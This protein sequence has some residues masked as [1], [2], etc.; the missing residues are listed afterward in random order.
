M[1]FLIVILL[2][3]LAALVLALLAARVLGRQRT[4][5]YG[6]LEALFD[7]TPDRYAH[8][9]RIL[10]HEDFDFLA[11]SRR[12]RELLRRLRQQ[13]V[14]LMQRY[15]A[16]M[17]EE[18]ESLMAVGSL[19]AAAPTA[20]A[21]NFARR[22]F[23]QRLRFL[24]AF[25]RLQACTLVNHV[26]AWPPDVTLLDTEIRTLRRQADRVLHALTPEDLGALR[27]FLRSS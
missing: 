5:T 8:L 9:G 27:N 3:A 24:I 20:Q 6:D 12:G 4:A 10:G 22:L 15:L 14:G 16:Q 23:R 18:F 13:R 7:S 19:F 21:E 25:Y 17:G 11:A 2:A 1:T 26:W